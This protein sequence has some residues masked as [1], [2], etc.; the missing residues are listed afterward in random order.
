M[1]QT[2]NCIHKT[3][4]FYLLSF[5]YGH[6]R[7]NI[8]PPATTDQ[9][10]RTARPK[11]RPRSWLLPKSPTFFHV[12]M[13]SCQ[14][15]LDLP[16]FTDIPVRHFLHNSYRKTYILIRNATPDIVY[17]SSWYSQNE[18]RTADGHK[19]SRLLQDKKWTAQEKAVHFSLVTTYCFYAGLPTIFSALYS[20]SHQ[21]KL[22][23]SSSGWLQ[24]LLSES[25]RW[26]IRSE[27]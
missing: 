2:P 8:R 26:L 12:L 27:A 7:R 15:Y 17:R 21:R 13:N 11:D 3:S 19:Q 10:L 16:N 6:R 9:A 18:Q 5:G 23:P 1:S 4:Y 20:L 14:G 22:N 25:I 24:S